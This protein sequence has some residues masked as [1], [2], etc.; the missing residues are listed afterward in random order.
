MNISLETGVAVVIYKVQL[1]FLLW[2]LF[3]R[4][5]G[6]FYSLFAPFCLNFK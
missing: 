2:F 3:G 6:S 4:C 5:H 1:E